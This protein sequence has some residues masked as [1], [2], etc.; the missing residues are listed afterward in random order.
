MALVLSLSAPVAL[1][2]DEDTMLETVRVLGILS[3]Y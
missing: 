3:V 2:A 1:A